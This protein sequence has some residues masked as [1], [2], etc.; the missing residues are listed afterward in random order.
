MSGMAKAR[1]TKLKKVQSVEDIPAF[2]SEEEEARFWS[3]HGFGKQMLDRME[4]IGE[5]WLP[6]PRARTR[7]VSVR[8]DEEMLRRLKAMAA[9]RGKRYQTLLKQFVLERLYEEERR[10]EKA[11]SR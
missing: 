5:D 10:E 4:P 2:A 8:L 6:P 11:E 7:P 3:E 1:T 9:R